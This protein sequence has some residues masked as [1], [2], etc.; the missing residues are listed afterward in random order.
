VSKVSWHSQIL[1]SGVLRD[2]REGW[3]GEKENSWTPPDPEKNKFYA[4]AKLIDGLQYLKNGF[5]AIG[6]L[7]LSTQLLPTDVYSS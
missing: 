2:G 6:Q 7:S 5:R 3:T 1:A 4:S